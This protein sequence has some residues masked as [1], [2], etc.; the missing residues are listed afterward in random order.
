MPLLQQQIWDLIRAGPSGRRSEAVDAAGPRRPHARMGRRRPRPRAR[1][2]SLASM[3]G[4]DVR[5]PGAKIW[6]ATC[7]SWPAPDPRWLAHP[8][9]SCREASNWSAC[10][11]RWCGVPN[12]EVPSLRAGIARELRSRT[13]CA[14]STDPRRQFAAEPAAL[15]RT[16][17]LADRPIVT[18]SDA[19]EVDR[20]RCAVAPAR[21]CF[22]EHE[23]RC[24]HAL[25]G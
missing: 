24:R 21:S 3:Q 17:R 1:P 11:Q 10:W 5:P 8:G 7:A 14:C 16:S 20:R 13:G 2:S 18:C 4:R 12:L 9:Q 22:N 25:C 19:L 23:F 6:T 15:A